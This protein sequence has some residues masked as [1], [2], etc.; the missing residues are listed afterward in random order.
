MTLHNLTDHCVKRPCWFAKQRHHTPSFCHENTVKGYV[1]VA[2][3]F[4]NK[5]CPTQGRVILTSSL[6]VTCTYFCT[7][8]FP[9]DPMIQ[10][11]NFK[12]LCNNSR[13]KTKKSY[14]KKL[15]TFLTSLLEI[16]WQKEV[17]SQSFYGF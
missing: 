9:W 1:F 5:N 17:F 15:Q 11:D 12:F 16:L 6:F 2:S 14:F 10:I 3:F 4:G 7:N 13:M 8:P